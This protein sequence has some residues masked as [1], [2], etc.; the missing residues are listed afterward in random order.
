MRILSRFLAKLT[1]SNGALPGALRGCLAGGIVLASSTMAAAQQPA[2]PKPVPA[3][4]APPKPAPPATGGDPAAQ[5]A[6]PGAAQPAP[7]SSVPAQPPAEA[8]GE[9]RGDEPLIPPQSGAAPV[10]PAPAR[11][12]AGEREAKAPE[13]QG[14]GR[15]TRAGEIGAQPSDV[16]AEDWWSQARPVFEIHGYYRVRAELFHKFALGRKD[17]SPLFWPQPADNNYVD[18][19]GV[20]HKIALCDAFNAMPGEEPYKACSNNTHAGANMRFRL[21]PELHISDNLR[22]M[23]QIDVLDNVML[24]STP[25]GYANVPRDGGYRVG[26]RGGYTPFGAFATTQWTPVAGVNSA[27]DS[28]SV[29]RVWGEYT[30]PIGVLHFG[31]MPAHW[32]L[33]IL[34]NRGDGYDS[35]YQTTVDRIML[36]TGVKRWDLYFAGAWDFANEGATSAVPGQSEGQPHDV[37]QLDDVN[38]YVLMAVRRRAPELQRLEL[39]KGQPVINGGMYFMYRNQLIAN[40]QTSDDASPSLGQSSDSVRNGYVRRG[41]KAYIPDVWFQFL[42]RKFR[43]EL[44]A[45]G[46]VGSLEN[47]QTSLTAVTSGTDYTN[48]DPAEAKNPGWKIRQFGIATQTEFR[49]I[50]DRL[51]LQFGFGYASGDPDVASLTPDSSGLSQQLTADRTFSEFR[52]HP[53]Y[54]VDLILHRHILNRVQGSYYFRP[55]VE[56]DFARDKNGQRLGGGAAVI[57]SRASEFIQ[58]PGHAHDLG[59]ELNGQLYY[60]SKDGTL[61][62][63]PDKMGGFFTSL[64]YGVLFPLK[65]LGFLADSSVKTELKTETAQTVRWFLGILY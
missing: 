24:G 39:S 3:K 57:W 46:V 42:Y 29:K 36:V 37:A 34:A 18:S 55:S 35:D 16:Y 2:P 45:V 5:P 4:P 65:G 19:A 12:Q 51:R 44:E 33:G 43:F 8:P 62:D 58:T 20:E 26:A 64:Q 47:T 30:T 9:S 61:N 32:G 41:Y 50:E 10:S 40:D 23:S 11:A 14:A 53:D 48:P 31:R 49:A 6:N 56:Y 60:Q 21:S 15:P 27:T 54:R 38:Q 25:S 59:I 52:F 13:S 7:G 1:R 63:D 17:S 28:I 22:V